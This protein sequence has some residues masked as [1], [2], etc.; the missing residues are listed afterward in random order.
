MISH[1]L[2]VIC[3]INGKTVYVD[4]VFGTLLF[5]GQ[6]NSIDQGLKMDRL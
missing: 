5:M 6:P 3:C 4:G 2:H 1:C